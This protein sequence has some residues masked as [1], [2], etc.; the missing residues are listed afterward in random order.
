MAAKQAAEQE[1]DPFE[2]AKRTVKGSVSAIVETMVERAKQGS[3]SHAKTLLELAGGKRMFDGETVTQDSGERWA[4][5]V[6][7]RLSEAESAAEQ[8]ALRAQAGILDL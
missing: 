3:C 2:I 4:K 6:L 7:E 5:L 1:L 8:E